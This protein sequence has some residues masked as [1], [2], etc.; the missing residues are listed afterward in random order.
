LHLRPHPLRYPKQKGSSAGRRIENGDVR[1]AQSLGRRILA[2]RSVES[3][4][5]VLNNLNGRIVDAVSLARRRVERLQKVFVEVE[6]GV[7]LAR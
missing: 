2:K 5:H 6:D 4:H 3:A 7:T 1:I